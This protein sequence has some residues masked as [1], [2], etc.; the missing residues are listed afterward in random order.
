MAQT[1]CLHLNAYFC[2]FA[3][4]M[5]L[6]SS[7]FPRKA[8]TFLWKSYNHHR[9]ATI[10]FKRKKLFLHSNQQIMKKGMDEEEGWMKKRNG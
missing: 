9:K 3:L 2:N 8:T 7:S 5:H 1:V 6:K 4:N 10:T